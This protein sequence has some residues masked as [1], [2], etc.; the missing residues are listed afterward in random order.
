MKFKV[1]FSIIPFFLLLFLTYGT[2]LFKLALF[3][4]GSFLSYTLGVLFLIPFI[5]LLIYYRIG[6]FYGVAL[7]SLALLLIE[8]A[9]MDRHSAPKEHY[10]IL[11]LAISLTFPAYA[12]IV[13]LAP[14]MPPLEVTM[15]AA[16]MLL[17]LYGISLLIEHGQTK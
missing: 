12:L 7:V 17:V 9:Q 14:I 4:F 3:S 5:I 1:K 6:G 10:L 8:S 11:T 13:L 2:P 15:I 16:L